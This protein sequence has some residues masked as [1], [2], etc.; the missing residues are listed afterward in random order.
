MTAPAPHALSE[1]KG[2]LDYRDYALNTDHME[3]YSAYQRRYA[4]KIRESDRVLIGLVEAE[5]SR[6]PDR[7][8]PGRLLDI[9]CSTGNLLLHLKRARPELQ[10]VGGDLATEVIAACRSDPDLSGVQFED[11]N[12]LDLPAGPPF[13]VV[14]ANASMMFFDDDEFA[15]AV[16]AIARALVPGG[17]LLA[18]DLFHPFSQSLTIREASQV[19]PDGIEFRFRPY[20][21][22]ERVLRTA[23][24]A[25]IEFLPF[26]IPIDLPRPADLGTA[27]YTVRITDGGRLC[28]RGALSQP[29]CHMVARRD[30]AEAAP[31]D[32]VP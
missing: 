20:R 7:R 3:L 19:R 1:P 24:F 11:M 17:A 6:L 10:L 8:R 28:F 4:T 25:R 21:V 22:V 18:F 16:T 15:T 13:D 29:W 27:S 26:S 12:M 9:G 2:P 30:G 32:A 23:G 31:G 5:L 14:V